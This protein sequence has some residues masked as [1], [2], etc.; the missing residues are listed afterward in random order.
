MAPWWNDVPYYLPQ[1]YRAVSEIL[2]K[3]PNFW[4]LIPLNPWIIF[5]KNSGFVSSYIIERQFHAKNVIENYRAVT[6][7]FKEGPMDR[8]TNQQGWSPWTKSGTP[9]VQSQILTLKIQDRYYKDCLLHRAVFKM[10]VCKY[11]P[12]CKMQTRSSDVT[13][14][15]GWYPFTHI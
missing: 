11:R 15:S 6:K 5:F 8:Q 10:T 7:I 4:K 1:S 13:K 14:S 3:D 12:V 2:S 9:E